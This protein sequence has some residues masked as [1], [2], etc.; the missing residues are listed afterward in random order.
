MDLR[1]KWKRNVDAYR[2]VYE[3]YWSRMCHHVLAWQF[4]PSKR[5]QTQDYLVEFRV[6]QFWVSSPDDHER[7]GDPR[8]EME[9]A[10]EILANTPA[11]IP[12]FGWVGGDD[13]HE[14]YIT[15]YMFSHLLSEYGKFI[16]G[17]DLNSNASVHSAIRLAGADALFRQRSREQPCRVKLEKDK[18]YVAFSIMDGDGICVWQ[19]WWQHIFADPMRGSVPMGYGMELCTIDLMPLVQRWYYDHATPAES[20]YGLVYI[21]EP[22]FANRFRKAD[23]ER[24][25]TRWIRYVDEHCRLLDLD[26][27]ELLW[28]GIRQPNLPKEGVLERYTKGIKGLNYIMAE[29]G[30]GTRADIPTDECTYR[31]DDTIVFHTANSIHTWAADEDLSARTM[32]KENSYVLD[33]LARFAPKRRPAFVNILG[34]VWRYRASWI[35]DLRRKLPPNYILVRPCDLAALYREWRRRGPAEVN[36]GTIKTCP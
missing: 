16:P 11:C 28:S 33:E 10:H 27:V 30:R 29:I 5:Y 1:G 3:R 26:A 22:V 13:P 4:P 6:F 14:T 18:V 24:I 25:W 15:E 32:E 12:V 35:D 7:G 19:G 17:T 9:F 20:F 36:V 31:L 34:L 23:R 8:A 21:N 2:W